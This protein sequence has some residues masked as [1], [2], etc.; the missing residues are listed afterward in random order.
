MVMQPVANRHSAEM[1]CEGSNPSL[2]A[3]LTTIKDVPS[4]SSIVSFSE[5]PSIGKIPL[6]AEEEYGLHWKSEDAIATYHHLF[7][8]LRT[9]MLQIKDAINK[10]R[11]EEDFINITALQGHQ[12]HLERMM[13]NIKDPIAALR[14]IKF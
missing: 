1:G 8:R 7:C 12:E 3:K 10:A 2:T 6:Y 4:S 11:S 9:V 13:E 14:R 5:P